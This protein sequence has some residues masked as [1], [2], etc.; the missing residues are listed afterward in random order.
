MSTMQIIE[1]LFHNQK[2][3]I[4]ALCTLSLQLDKWSFRGLQGQE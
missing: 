2:Q 1:I 4:C 3:K